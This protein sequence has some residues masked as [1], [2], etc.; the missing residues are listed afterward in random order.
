M[1]QFDVC[2]LKNGDGQMVVVLQ[3][4]VADDLDTRI[5]APLSDVPYRNLIK[6]IRIPVAVAGTSYVIQLDRMAAI[7]R[8]EIGDVIGN[9]ADEEHQ[10]KNALDLLFL[11][12]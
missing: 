5:V 9:L 2:R 12:V 4:D 7:A 3:H 8:R 1:R 11:G 6:R 10:I